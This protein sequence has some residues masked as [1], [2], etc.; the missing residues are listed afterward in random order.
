MI[1]VRVHGVLAATAATA[2]T[3][4]VAPLAAS[5]AEPMVLLAAAAAAAVAGCLADPAGGRRARWFTGMAPSIGALA[6]VLVALAVWRPGPTAMVGAD[7][8]S[9]YRLLSESLAQLLAAP[10]PIPATVATVT[11]PVLVTWFAVAL[12]ARLWRRHPAVRLI[13]SLFLL[14]GVVVFQGPNAAPA[15]LPT[16]VFAAAAAGVLTASRNGQPPIRSRHWG[17]VRQTAT[18]LVACAIAA[19]LLGQLVGLVRQRPPGD[20]RALLMPAGAPTDVLSPLSHLAAWARN[21]D[22][23]LLEVAVDQPVELRWVALGR[24]DGV[25]WLPADRYPASGA[26]LPG[27]GGRDERRGRG[28][29]GYEITV[30]GLPGGWVPMPVGTGAIRGLRV[31]Y[32]A[33]SASAL[34][35]GGLHPGQRYMVVPLAE[36]ALVPA[37]G[38][39]ALRAYL[40]VP[41]GVPAPLRHLA[42]RTAPDASPA[43]RI[44]AL[45]DAVRQQGRLDPTF[46][47]GHGYPTLLNMLSAPAE[48]GGGRGSSVQFAAMLAVV[49]R[50]CGIPSRV[51]VAL[52]SRPDGHGGQRVLAGDAYAYTEVLLPDGWRA[53][54]ARPAHHSPGSGLSPLPTGAGAALAAADS[55]ETQPTDRPAETVSPDPGVRSG[56]RAAIVF[57]VL[58]A[59]VLGA[60]PLARWLRSRRRIRATDPAQCL[61]GAWAEV[62]DAQRLAGHRPSSSATVG[63]IARA[64]DGKPGPRLPDLTDLAGA[65]NAVGFAPPHH[66]LSEQTV[67]RVVG[68]AC[69]YRRA[70][71]RGS[72]R[73]RRLLWHLDPRP[74]LWRH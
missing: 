71:R 23:V 19:T 52:P 64:F 69:A 13:P 39:A 68:I 63:R 57:P 17:G 40:A 49:A 28:A 62:R 31:G 29:R 21:P 6:L 20:P 14:V 53:I 60:V 48:H 58:L 26:A 44:T 32:D 38:D 18:I 67:R 70:V 30:A 1:A 7:P 9:V 36:P 47:G 65:V 55:S 43:D 66:V 11:F 33:A 50:L 27:T 72:P 24:F 54:D 3:A 5:F 35:P 73:W 37:T 74:L 15:F 25:D 10:I 34:A 59:V 2:A 16:A 41:D 56:D 4:A 22:Q 46:I 42:G 51:V 61:L 12:P 45:R 8:R